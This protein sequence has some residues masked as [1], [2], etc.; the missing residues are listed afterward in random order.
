MSS[1]DIAAAAAGI[2]ATAPVAYL[3][4]AGQYD[5]RTVLCACADER[6]AAEL[7][8]RGHDRHQGGQA[9]AG[10]GPVQVLEHAGLAGWQWDAGPGTG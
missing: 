1:S 9:E 3:V 8:D 10:F 5:D 2:P 7:A 4:V 6:D